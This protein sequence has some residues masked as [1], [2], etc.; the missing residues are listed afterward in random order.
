MKKHFKQALFLA[1]GLF[2]LLAGD[3][4]LYITQAQAQANNAGNRFFISAAPQFSYSN[5]I[6]I[7]W[8]GGVSL[9]TTNDRR[10]DA[11][12]VDYQNMSQTFDAGGDISNLLKSIPGVNLN[13]DANAS[14]TMKTQFA[15]ITYD[16]V[17]KLEYDQFVGL[18]GTGAGIE[19]WILHVT[20]AAVAN[21]TATVSGGGQTQTQTQSQS[22]GTDKEVILGGLLLTPRI[23]FEW[24]ATDL[25]ALGMNIRGFIDLPA[26]PLSRGTIDVTAKLTF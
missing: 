6:G 4:G 10:T 2:V 26:F 15:A 11:F 20:A 25:L 21:A 16:Y 7:G 22:S 24:N 1:G 19:G 18:I 5:F 8:G 9:G 17:A 12:N 14:A 13:V 23:G 3:N